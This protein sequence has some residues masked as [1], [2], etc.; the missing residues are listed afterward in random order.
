MV[1]P[2]PASKR[3]MRTK[4]VLPIDWVLSSNIAMLHLVAC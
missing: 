1:T 4:G 3:L 2:V